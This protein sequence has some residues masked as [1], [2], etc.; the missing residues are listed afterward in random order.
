MA[1]LN[2]RPLSVNRKSP[3]LTGRRLGLT[4]GLAALS[5]V[6]FAL[7]LPRGATTQFQA[8]VLLP[9]VWASGC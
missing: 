4:L 5:G 9:V 1:A 7:V 2:S 6:L 3:P 8:L